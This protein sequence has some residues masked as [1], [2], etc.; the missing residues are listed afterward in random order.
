MEQFNFYM[1]SKLLFGQGQLDN[2]HKQV[3]PG[4]KALIVIGGTS[5]K[6][7]GYIN[8]VEEQL[9]KACVDFVVYDKIQPNPTK[10]EVM[11][12]SKI[13]RE[14]KCD[15]VIGLG[16]GSPIDS[17]KAIAMMITNDGDLWDYFSGGTAKGNPL[18]NKPLPIVAITTTAGTGTEADPW[19]VITN[20]ETNE[21][22]GFGN[23][24]TYPTLSIIDPNLMMTVPAKLTAYQG[25]DALFHSLEGYI[26]KFSNPVADIF[27]LKSIELIGKSL[28]ISV[29]DGTNIEARQNVAIANTLSGINESTSGCT[30]EHAIEHALSGYH[31]E[32]PHGA[33]LIMISKEYFT[34]MAKSGTC[35][36]KL[37]DL[38]KAM[39]NKNAN[40]AMDFVD[41]LVKLQKACNVDELKMSDYGIKKEEMKKYAEKAFNIM[42]GLFSCDP[43]QLSL[44][45]VIS[46]LE[47]SYK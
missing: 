6:K 39:G 1:P 42:P 25:F 33:G 47:K 9:K 30:S 20:T 40:N 7:Y 16:G 31:P 41:E 8:K 22:I 28:A 3:L 26:N 2:L 23:D 46:I 5:V 18:K 14:A 45:N 35:N 37:I 44:N 13:G 43:Q 36:Q 21:K 27:A 38:A 4:K 34:F 19:L 32:L 17:S 15:F 24:D 10:N 12:A 29:N 11:E